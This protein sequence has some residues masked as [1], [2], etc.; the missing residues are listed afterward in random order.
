MGNTVIMTELRVFGRMSW[1]CK[2]YEG[3]DMLR[4]W[5][6]SVVHFVWGGVGR[7]R[8]NASILVRGVR[9]AVGRLH[10]CGLAGLLVEVRPIR[11]Y[12]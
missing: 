1:G 2:R 12:S 3:S 11:G 7:K 10:S 4:V 6:W 9:I 5:Y 8:V